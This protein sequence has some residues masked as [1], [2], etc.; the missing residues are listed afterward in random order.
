MGY[1][2]GYNPR[3]GRQ[4]LACDGC[5]AVG[6]VRKRPCTE[7]VL[8]SSLR[9]VDGQRHA[10]RYCQ[11]PALCSECFKKHGSSKGIHAHC[12]EPA[13]LAQAEYDEEQ[14]RL[15]SGDAKVVARYGS[16]HDRV[17]EGRVMVDYGHLNGHVTTL[18][19]DAGSDEAR[20][21]WLLEVI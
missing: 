7:K 10:L 12:V 3:T 11:A 18:F 17:P 13:A 16:W 2:Y 6:G 14:R 9:T 21:D 5:S 20:A 1:G 19:H 15:E 8:G 4:V